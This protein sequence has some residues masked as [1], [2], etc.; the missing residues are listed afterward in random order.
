MIS[1]RMKFVQLMRIRRRFLQTKCGFMQIKFSFQG[2]NKKGPTLLA[3]NKVG[4]FGV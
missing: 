1:P 4:P 2:N 3:T